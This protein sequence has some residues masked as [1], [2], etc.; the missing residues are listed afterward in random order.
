MVTNQHA[1]HLLSLS[2]SVLPVTRWPRNELT[3]LPRTTLKKKFDALVEV[4]E[5]G[6]KITN[7]DIVT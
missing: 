5:T 3:G 2:I 4:H 7:T 1:K 6:R